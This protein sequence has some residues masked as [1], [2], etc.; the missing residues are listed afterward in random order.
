MVNYGATE[1][2]N[3][4]R[5][6]RKNT[7]Q[8]AREI[9]EDK[10]DFSAAPGVRTV[11]ELLRHI[12]FLNLMHYDFHRDKRVATLQ[13]YDFPKL[14]GQITAEGDQLRSKDEIIDA[15]EKNGEAFATWLQSLTPDFLNETYTDSTGRNPRSRFEHL[16]SAKEHEM[17]HRGQLMLI[18]RMLGITPHLTRQ[19]ME[20][21]RAREAAAT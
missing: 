11:R 15:L 20:R 5:T 17:H 16:L 13:G 10:Y 21:M 18:Q 9:P 7:V 14:I 2:A 8:T 1:L 6:V 12:A 4:F 19:M 3:A